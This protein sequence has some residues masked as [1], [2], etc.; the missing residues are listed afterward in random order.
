M[1]K[2][3]YIVLLNNNEDNIPLLIK[4]LKE[5]NGPFRKEFIIIDDGSKDNSLKLV[6]SAAGDLSRTTIITQKNQGWAISINEAINLATGNYIHF[7]EGDE[8]LHPESTAIMID[9]CV[10]FGTKVS[11]ARIQLLENEKE[12]DTFKEKLST[13]QKLVQSPI[14]EILLNQI[15]A[16]RNVGG[17]G[18]LVQRSLIEKAGKADSSIYSQTMSLSLRCAK[19]SNFVF[20]NNVLSFK[21]KNTVLKEKEFESYNNLRAIYNFAINHPDVCKTLTPELLKNLGSETSS[22]KLKFIYYLWFKKAKY[23][24][25]PTLSKV[26]EF[27][28]IE[29][30][31]LF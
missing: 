27:Y 19:Y 14:N 7:V 18:T 15:P 12:L 21:R 31:K 6:K 20:I 13:E 10:K 28:K 24:N 9:S 17:S 5:I 1:L 3:T 11:C 22:N 29:Y 23:T 4:S 16:L 8:I 2:C 26:L 25:S 30:E